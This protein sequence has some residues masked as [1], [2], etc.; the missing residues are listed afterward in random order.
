MD[1]KFLPAALAAAILAL[2]GCGSS[3]S[4]SAPEVEPPPPPPPP[5]AETSTVRIVHASADAPNVNILIDGDAAFDDVPFLAAT[6]LTELDS[7]DYEVQVDGR[8]PGD[9]ITTVIGPVTLTLEADTQYNILAIGDVGGDGIE[10]LVLD[11]PANEIEAGNVRAR[12][13]HAAPGAPEVEVYVTEPGDLAPGEPPLGSFEFGGDLGPVEVPEGEYQIRVAVPGEEPIVVFD[14]GPISLPGG[15]DLLIA[16]VTNT[17]PGESP[18]TLLVSDGADAFN[19]LDIGTPATARVVHASPDAG[20]VDVLVDDAV[21][22]P[23]LAFPEFTG[24]LE[25]D[26]GEYNVKVT[27]AGNPGTVAIEADLE[28]EIGVEYA[29]LAVGEL[30]P[31]TI[32]ALV[33]VDDNRR[34]A[35]EAK[36][37][38]VH[39]SPNAGPVDIYVT[40]VGDAIEEA[41][42]AIEGFEFLAQT[43]YLSLPAGNYDVTVTAT[44]TTTP[45][46]G[47][48]TIALENGGIYTAIA[49][50]PL[51][52]DTAFGLILLD[53]FVSDD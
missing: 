51:P 45:A 33:L 37:R 22:V 2:A 46:I 3:S 48:A 28:L 25:L 30:G 21:A 40:G 43:G 24:Y 36:V 34:V 50:D 35:T 6:P 32:D 12:V 27:P 1:R 47:P 17:G 16:A 53:D 39:G 20:N 13:V 8:L 19:L 38:I 31:A 41:D 10:A 26:P 15:A 52:G 18:I 7:G 23:N 42:P 5:P 49:R 11:Q 44:G 4:S 9:E 29:V 14:S